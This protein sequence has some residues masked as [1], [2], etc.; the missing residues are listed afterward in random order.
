VTGGAGFIGSH[1]VEALVARGQ[2]VRVLDDFSTGKSGN[3]DAVAGRIELIRGS[4]TD[5]AAVERAVAGVEQV[6]HLAAIPSVQASLEDPAATHQVIATGTLTVLEAARRAG[7]RRLVYFS[8]CA[9][10]GNQP[11]DVRRE[12]DP[13][14]PLS[15]YAAAKLAGEFYCTC[16]TAAYGLP[17]VRLRLF[18]VFGPRQDSASP[19]AGVI[20]RFSRDLAEGRMPTIYGDGWQSRDFLHVWD[21]VQA[22][23]LAAEAPAA[24]GKVYNIGSGQSTAIRTLADELGRLLGRTGQPRFAPARAGEVRHSRADIS[25]AQRDLGFQPA[26]TLVEGLRRMLG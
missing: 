3:L 24:A 2:P 23:L 26:I 17:T 5:T 21:A 25:R 8:T 20:A 7:V 10:Y 13:P 19:Y 22:A 16:Y 18:N 1:L 6:F 11:G 15:P 4:V 9:V 12:D 14:A